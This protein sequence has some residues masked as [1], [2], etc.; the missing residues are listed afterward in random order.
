[1]RSFQ[2]IDQGLES[3][4]YMN[5]SHG[6][7]LRAVSSDR[8][9]QQ[10]IWLWLSMQSQMRFKDNIAD[11][12]IGPGHD[13]DFPTLGYEAWKGIFLED[14]G[15]F[16][17]LLKELLQCYPKDV[18]EATI[19]AWSIWMMDVQWVHGELRRMWVNHDDDFAYCNN[20]NALFMT[21]W[22]SSKGRKWI[23]YLCLILNLK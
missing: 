2:A 18:S 15:R 17:S 4:E 6:T 21:V 8:S 9:F 12:I 13:L 20:N 22:W 10:W 7:T 16:Y 5:I 1:M 19:L 14:S 3:S 11:M 23:Q